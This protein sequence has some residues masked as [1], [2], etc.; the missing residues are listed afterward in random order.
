ME[1]LDV[2]IVLGEAGQHPLRLRVQCGRPQPQLTGESRDGE[3]MGRQG[4]LRRE[5]VMVEY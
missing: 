5:R 3:G 1:V 2:L 4:V